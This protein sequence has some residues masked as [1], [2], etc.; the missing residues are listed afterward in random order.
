[1][2]DTTIKKPWNLLPENIG[3]PLMP[4]ISLHKRPERT[5]SLDCTGDAKILNTPEL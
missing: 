4:G 5:N 2:K 3:E 1:M